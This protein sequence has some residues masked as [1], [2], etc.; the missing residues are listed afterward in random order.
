MFAVLAWIAKVLAGSNGMKTAGAAA[1]GSVLSVAVL[2]GVLDQSVDKK[3]DTNIKVITG[4][5][6]F[7]H[8]RVSND[9]NYIKEDIREVKDLLK[10]V[11][12]RVYQLNQRN[13]GE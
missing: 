10:T 12:D 6:D 2:M 7:K 5:V 11:N 13:K 4:Y 3:I 1:G 9:I 8:D